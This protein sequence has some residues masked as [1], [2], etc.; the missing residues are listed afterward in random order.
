MP[1]NSYVACEFKGSILRKILNIRPLRQVFNSSKNQLFRFVNVL[2][3]KFNFNG[4]WE[5]HPPLENRQTVI[6]NISVFKDTFCIDFQSGFRSHRLDPF[7]D[8]PKWAKITKSPMH[9]TTYESYTSKI[10][11]GALAR[12]SLAIHLLSICINKLLNAFL[13]M[14]LDWS[15]LRLLFGC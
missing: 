6:F 9:G 5:P 14:T 8:P 7:T 4:M 12:L 15:P 11:G 2:M 13:F 10:A 1:L 3:G